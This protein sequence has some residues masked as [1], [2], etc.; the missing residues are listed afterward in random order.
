MSPRTHTHSLQHAYLQS[1]PDGIQPVSVKT[2]LR[3]TLQ[4]CERLQ[5]HHDIEEA[6]VFPAFAAVTDISH[7]SHSHEALDAT[8][9]KIRA[10]AL[11]GLSNDTE[12]EFVT[13]KKQ[14]VGELERLSDIVLSHLSDEEYLSHPDELIKLWPTGRDMLQAFPWMPKDVHDPTVVH[15]LFL[16]LIPAHIRK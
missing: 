3:Q 8:L 14:L 1:L 13:T 5:R 11:Q 4:F 9:A 2:L 7:W 6:V 10:L 15:L 16:T 12:N